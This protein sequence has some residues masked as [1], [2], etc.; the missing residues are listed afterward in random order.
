M[1]VVARYDWTGDADGVRDCFRMPGEIGRDERV[2][3]EPDADEP[4]LPKRQHVDEKELAVLRNNVALC[5]KHEILIERKGKRE[6]NKERDNDRNLIRGEIIGGDANEYIHNRRHRPDQ[7]K[8]RELFH[9]LTP[10]T[11]NCFPKNLQNSGSAR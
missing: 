5:S 1:A 6:R 4:D 9:S 3:R 7:N 2:A 8:Q 11:R 10:T